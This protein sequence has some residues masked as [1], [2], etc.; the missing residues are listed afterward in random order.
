MVSSQ[1]IP[2]FAA[3]VDICRL[4]TG[5]V[6]AVVESIQSDTLFDRISRPFSDQSFFH[7]HCAVALLFFSAW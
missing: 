3:H 5:H 6:N 2:S 7:D 1:H 4:F